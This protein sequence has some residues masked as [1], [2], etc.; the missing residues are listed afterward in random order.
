M[1]RA[2]PPVEETWKPPTKATLLL[3]IGIIVVGSV[4]GFAAFYLVGNAEEAPDTTFEIEQYGE[5]GQYVRIGNLSGEPIEDPGTI[6]VFV[7]GERVEN[8]TG[9]DWA[10]S[11]G[12]LDEDSALY[13]ARNANG[14]TVIADQPDHES[15]DRGVVAGDGIEVLW[16]STSSDSTAALATHEVEFVDE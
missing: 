11:E 3:V 6:V 16:A 10:N 15:F 5:D 12:A 7:D 2:D 9:H 4:L 8:N 13:V 1:S 14:D